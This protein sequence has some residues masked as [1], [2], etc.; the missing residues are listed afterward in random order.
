MKSFLWAVLLATTAFLLSCGDSNSSGPEPAPDPIPGWLKVRF[1]SPNTDDGGIMFT[2][3]GAQIDSVR[4]AYPDLFVSGGN[5]SPKHIIV[6]GSLISG[7]L[8]EIKVP[9]V[10][11]VAEYT[12]T[13]GQVAARETFQ[14]RQ[15]S[16]FSLV[17]ER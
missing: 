4:S 8:V 1:D 14:Q 11:S 6:A 9:D 15:V 12:A 16:T 2:L 13:V 3:S 17:V 7:L 5:V 10:A